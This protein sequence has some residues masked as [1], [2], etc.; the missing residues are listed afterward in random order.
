M[1]VSWSGRVRV[2]GQL[3]CSF[4]IPQRRFCTYAHM[5][6]TMP[7]RKRDGSE[8]SASDAEGVES[9]VSIRQHRVQHKLE[10]AHKQLARAFKTAKG[11]EAQKSGRRRKTAGA[12][13]DEKEVA[14]IEGET[15]ALKTLDLAATSRNYLHKSLIKFKAVAESPDLPKAVLAPPPPISDISKANVIARLC[16]SNPVKEALPPLL[17]DIQKAL[18][19]EVKDVKEG[20]KRLRAKDIEKQKQ[21]EQAK[22]QPPKSSRHAAE[23]ESGDI[24]MGEPNDESDIEQR[25]KR[26]QIPESTGNGSDDEFAEFDDRLAGSSD[27]EDEAQSDNEAVPTKGKASRA[28]ALRAALG[29]ISQSASVS[30]S[31]SPSPS[32]SRSPSPESDA[33]PVRATKAGTSAF[34]PSLTMGGYW[35]GSESEAEDFEDGPP[36]KNRRGQRA[37]QAIAEKKFGKSAKHLQNQEKANKSDR[38]SGWDAKRGATDRTGPR[39]ARGAPRGRFERPGQDRGVR[40]DAA[41]PPKKKHRDDQGPIHPS[42]EAAKKAK[43]AKKVTA[44]FEGKKISFD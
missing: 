43:E 28:A 35:S 29:D 15:A 32:P 23:P 33:P 31:P 9:G 39:G 44:V 26:K 5:Q 22:T 12:K 40:G 18:G 21:E 19:V 27:S 3:F 24:S 41:E 7:K 42:W 14:R 25:T 4:S 1:S 6:T 13:S 16:N 10:Y 17:K 8:A 2:L 20:K 34:V 38:N 11:F 37:R 36:K 30:P